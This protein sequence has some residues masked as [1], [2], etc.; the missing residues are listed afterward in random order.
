MKEKRSNFPN[1]KIENE[2]EQ[3]NMINKKKNEKV[4]QTNKRRKQSIEHEF[5]DTSD[6]TCHLFI[7]KA[8]HD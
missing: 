4:K 5:Y 1:S 6:I 3:T 2:S 8:R 7:S